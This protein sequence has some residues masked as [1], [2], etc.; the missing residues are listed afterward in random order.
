MKQLVR[1]T[2]LFLPQKLPQ[3]PGMEGAHEEE[4]L[5][6]EDDEDEEDDMEVDE[7]GGASG[8]RTLKLMQKP[9]DHLVEVSR[10]TISRR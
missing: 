3:T 8:D 10:P 7:K 4:E 1:H 6:S 2:A 5:E 9:P